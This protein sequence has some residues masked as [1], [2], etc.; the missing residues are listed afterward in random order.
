MSSTKVTANKED[1]C[2]SKGPNPQDEIK[3]DCQIVK[4]EI[5]VELE[6][7]V[8]LIKRELGRG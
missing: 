8:N 6:K 7:L 5:C 1:F 3:D 4:A 2:V